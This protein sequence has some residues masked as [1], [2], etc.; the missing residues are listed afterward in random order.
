MS[1]L[2]KSVVEKDGQFC[3]VSESS[4][5]SFGCYLNKDLATKRLHQIE[6]FTD[7]HLTKASDDTL[8]NLHDGCHKSE[9]TDDIVTL[10][11]LVE[12]QLEGRGFS[13]P[14]NTGSL[15]DK[16]AAVS[17]TV[18]LIKS[19]DRFSLAP[20]Y[21]PWLEDSDGEMIADDDLQ[22]SL[23]E[24]VKKGDRTIFLQHS[25]K[26]A[27]EMVELLTW[28]FEIETS[29]DVPNQ[30]VTKYAFPANT[31]FMGVIWEEWAWDLVKSGELRGYSIGGR[32]QRME[33]EIPNEAALG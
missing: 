23:W 17:A 24:W 22:K 5:R 18:P 20:V 30:G 7:K 2:T 11:D 21:V 6:R 32:A 3:V 12:D 25:E 8:I 1:D 15:E 27:G 14:Y 26:A 10:H 4:G 19:E 9:V 33:V 16:L 31:P 28:P 13:P 29:L